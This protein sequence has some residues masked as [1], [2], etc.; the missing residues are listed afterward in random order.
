MHKVF[1]NNIF[2]ALLLLFIGIVA[3]TPILFIKERFYKDA[4]FEITSGIMFIVLSIVIIC[5]ARAVN[6]RRKI[7]TTYGFAIPARLSAVVA[8]TV[9]AVLIFQ[10]GVNVPLSKMLGFY[11]NGKANYSSPFDQLGLFIGAIL[12]APLFEELI[13]R[14]IILK[15][16]LT[17]YTP[18]IAI[19]ISAVLFSAVHAQPVQLLGA[20][21]FGVLSG[22]L[23]YKTQ[24]LGLCILLH[25]LSNLS[26]QLIAYTLFKASSSDHLLK[27]E[28]YGHYTYFV[29]GISLLFICYF[30]FKVSDRFKTLEN[31]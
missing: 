24:S 16:F 31:S 19:M 21:F 27:P 2:Q 23:Y 25:F 28:V 20:L 10:I 13:F 22:W 11:L 4:S 14:G 17:K 8:L 15:G 12:L 1:P 7:T 3:T 30:I 18:A 5:V 6:S 29:I 26:S 9:A